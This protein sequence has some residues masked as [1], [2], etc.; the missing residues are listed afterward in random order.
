M[1]SSSSK[2]FIEPLYRTNAGAL[3]YHL[4][5]KSGLIKNKK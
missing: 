3:Q 5:V 2:I 1:A 4:Q